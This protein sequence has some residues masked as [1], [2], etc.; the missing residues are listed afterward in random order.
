MS[1]LYLFAVGLLSILG[2]VA[3]L[4][5]LNVA[6]YGV[7]LFYL[8][9]LGTWLLWGALG[10]LVGAMRRDVSPELVILLF[11][12]LGLILPLDLAFIRYSRLLLTGV[13]GAYLSFPRQFF[14]ILIALAPPGIVLGVLFQ[15]SARHYVGGEKSLARAYAIESLGGLAGGILSTLSLTWGIQNGALL[16]ASAIT[17]PFLALALPSGG[18][19]IFCKMSALALFCLLSLMLWQ[20]SSIHRVMTRWNYPAMLESLDTPYGR[21]TITRWADQV[22]VF[23]NGSLAFET[24]GTDAESICHLAALQHPRPKDVLILGGG[25]EGIVREMLK[26]DPRRIDYV[27]INYA[28]FDLVTKHMPRDTRE[29]LRDTRV[30]IFFADPRTFILRDR[31]YDLILIGM[32]EPSSGQANRFYTS[33]FFIQCAARLHHGGVLALRLRSAENYWTVPLGRRMASVYRSLTSV[34][35]HVQFLPGAVNVITASSGEL[36]RTEEEPIAHL[37]Q[38]QIRARL[39]TVPY[40][41]YLFTNDRYFEIDRFLKEEKAPLN[42]DAAPVC[43]RYTLMIWLSKFFPRINTMAYAPVLN[44]QLPG[45]MFL[46]SAWLSLAMLFLLSRLKPFCRRVLFVAFGGFTGMVIESVLLLHY[47]VKQGVLY[48][49]LGL[50]LMS[51]MLGLALGAAAVDRFAGRGR[52]NRSSLVKWGVSLGFGLILLCGLTLHVVSACGFK[53]LVQTAG[54]LAAAG[55]L[56]AGVF[57]YASLGDTEDP[58]GAIAALYAADLAGGCLGSVLSGLMLIPLYGLDSTAALITG[59]SILSILLV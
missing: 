34:F 10:A 57:A 30:H 56:V 9:A 11:L 38:R 1:P 51:F 6:L 4:R 18:K 8:L 28:M 19:S 43:Y 41:R 45:S 31:S 59:L 47:Q 40:I 49:D 2:Q 29:S 52:E 50:L 36:P 26:H 24:G 35:P 39:I 14:L 54:L 53:S 15:W 5:E 20:H 48:Q 44:G 46:W 7:E 32:P 33:D 16:L 23:E 3:L 27:E 17:T 13:P 22:S 58:K 55:F 37:Q 12:L 25:I 42:T 21:V